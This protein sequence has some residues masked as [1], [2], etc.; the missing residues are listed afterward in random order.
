[1]VRFGKKAAIVTAAGVLAAVSVA[2]CSS[3]L[4]PAAVVATVG[5]DAN[6]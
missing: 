5:G 2:G 3:T 6:E 1:M 4:N